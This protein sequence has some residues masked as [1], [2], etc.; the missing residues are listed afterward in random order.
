LYTNRATKFPPYL[1]A[2][3]AAKSK[4]FKNSSDATLRTTVIATVWE[5][6]FATAFPSILPTDKATNKSTIASAEYSTFS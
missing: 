6:Y 2:F 1:Q 4:T 5:A 3:S